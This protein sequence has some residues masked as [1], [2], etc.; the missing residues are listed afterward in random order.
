MFIKFLRHK[1]F[2]ALVVATTIIAAA[3]V[4]AA[5]LLLKDGRTLEGRYAE[6]TSVA[7]N[8]LAPKT[9]AGEVA[10]TPLLVIDDGLRRTYIHRNQVREILEQNSRRDVRINIW[11]PVAERG[12]GVGRIGQAVRVTPFDEFGRR[13]YEMR[14]TEGLLSV[15]QGITQITPVYTRVQGLTGLTRPVVWDMRLATSS[16]PRDTLSRILSTAVQRDDLEGRLQV[17]RLYLQSERYRDASTE[18]EQILKD[19]PERKDLEQD[20]RQLRQLAARL[21]LKEIELR[22]DAGQHQRVR[23][24]LDQFPSEGVAGETLAEVRERLD[25][26]AAED[27]R[28][29]NVLQELQAQVGKIA[30]ENGRRLAEDFAKEITEEANAEAIERLAS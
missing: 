3:P 25:K 17:V 8:P 22:A 11:Q 5:M 29:K 20:I 12:A 19:F 9:Q 6:L 7:E 21:I 4:E 27:A 15:V 18:L 30:D 24:F 13:I 26:Y 23:L 10:L 28:R 16:I 1:Q 14:S 2:A